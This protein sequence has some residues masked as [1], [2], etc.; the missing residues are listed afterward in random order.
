MPSFLPILLALA[1]SS[2]C[3][4]SQVV[5]TQSDPVL[6]KPGESHK[7][8]CAVTGFD[9]S[10]TWMNWVRQ[11][12]DKGLEWLVDYYGTASGQSYYSPAIQGRFTALKSGSNFYLQ[13][14]NLNVEDTAVYYCA[15]DTETPRSR[16]HPLL[17]FLITKLVYLI[18]S[19]MHFLLPFLFSLLTLPRWTLSDVQL[20]SSG[21]GTVRPGENLRLVCT[22]TGVS[23]TDAAYAWNW[24]HQPPGKSVEWIATIYPYNGNKLHNASFKSRATISSDTS[25]NEFFLQLNSL[26]EVD[27]A[28]YY[29]A[30][31]ATGENE[32]EGATI[33]AI[34]SLACIF[35]LVGME[36]W[37]QRQRESH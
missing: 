9:L 17:P 30:R 8:T 22:V 32:W 11:K 37:P 26:T 16:I 34:S 5:L 3:A 27:T 24:I 1:A 20:T 15:R 2:Q 21:P 6:K 7:L 4:L 36:E 23:I 25:K 29:C 28:V 14:N 13:M 18:F 33:I 31:H 19:I 10:S 12:P 35:P